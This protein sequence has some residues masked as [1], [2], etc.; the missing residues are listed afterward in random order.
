LVPGGVNP[1]IS[2]DG[3]YVVFETGDQ[4][5]V[6]DRETSETSVVRVDGTRHQMPSI[7]GDGRYIAFVAGFPFL[8]IYVYDRQTRQVTRITDGPLNTFPTLS[9]DGRFVAFTSS[10]GLTDP[11]H[12]LN[13]HV[14][15]HDRGTGATRLMSVD[16]A[17][18]AANGDSSAV[19]ISADGRFVAFAS[20]ATNLVSDDTNGIDDIFVHD[21]LSQATIRVSV[22][23]DG[24]QAEA[25]RAPPR[26]L[27]PFPR[28]SPGGSVRPSISADGTHVLFASDAT[29]LTPLTPDLNGRRDVFVH[30]LAPPEEVKPFTQDGRGLVSMEAEHF[31]LSLRAQEHWQ[32]VPNE[33]LLGP[34][35]PVSDRKASGAEAIRADPTWPQ[36]R[37]KSIAPTVGYSIH[38]NRTGS[39]YV[40]VRARATSSQG[41]T[42]GLGIDQ[43]DL[44]PRHVEP[45]TGQWVWNR[46]WTTFEVP[47][48]GRHTLWLYRMER[49]VE[50]D[51]IVVTPHRAFT[52][53]GKGPAESPRRDTNASPI[54]EAIGDK[55]V[56]VDE[57]LELTLK[58]TDADGDRLTFGVPDLPPFADLRDHGD[59]TATLS[60]SPGPGFV[61][62]HAI[63]V[64]V[65]DTGTPNVS[66]EEIIDLT[67]VGAAFQQGAGGM[68]TIESEHFDVALPGETLGP[69]SVIHDPGASRGQAIKAA[70]H[71][72]RSPVGDGPP[73]TEY[74][75][76]FNRTGIHHVWVRARSFVPSSD[77]F[78]VGLDDG[79]ALVRHVEPD[80]DQWV[81]NRGWNRI[82]VDRVGLHTFRI[83][84]LERNVEIDKIVITPWP[85]YTPMG[86][87]PGESRRR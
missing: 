21:R 24:L 75:V 77:A 27:L 48:P 32:A 43:Q 81:W 53:V 40:W 4:V 86:I 30:E 85:G 65:T 29:N 10:G 78:Y 45:D 72:A 63:K 87:G 61:G 55:I 44:V 12:Q 28:S 42:F 54:L 73:R 52:P 46:G 3:R 16:S 68:L 83:Y 79:P 20:G 76:H 26:D 84:R 71:W 62:T 14:Y 74:W 66:D 35:M 31:Y 18:N 37:Q 80:T 67:V 41:D 51:K 57:R 7:S 56:R 11:R 5:Y 39:H 2:A 64:T 6:Y 82:N 59:G 17:G 47:S 15:L 13:E 60:F 22:D 38:F 8:D 19:S 9:Y 70:G 58:A 34:W 36:T 50:I 33:G 1:N 69:W 25:S 49:R 23:S